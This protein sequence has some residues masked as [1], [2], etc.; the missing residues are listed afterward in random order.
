MEQEV[1]EFL[2]DIAD[3]KDDG[4]LADA[5]DS[6]GRPDPPTSFPDGKAR[7]L[8]PQVDNA[9]AALHH[10]AGGIRVQRAEAMGAIA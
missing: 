2:R 8:W 5:E 3:I 10:V 7:R 1:A 6:D 9:G 4:T